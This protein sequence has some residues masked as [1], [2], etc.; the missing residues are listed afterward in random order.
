[1][2]VS[3]KQLFT[4]F[5][6]N[7]TLRKTSGGWWSFKCPFCNE[8]ENREKMAIQFQYGVVKCWICSYKDYADRFVSEYEGVKLSEAKDILRSCKPATVK[9]DDFVGDSSL[10]VSTVALPVGYHSITEMEGN[11]MADRARTYLTKRGFDIQEL[12]R[13]GVGFCYHEEDDLK[14]DDDYFGYVIIPFKSK[15][16]LVYF[17]G[18]DYFGNFLRY[19]NPAKDLTGVGKGDVLFNEDALNIYDEVFILEGWADAL[20]MGRAAISTQG[21]SLSKKQKLK[22]LNGSCS[23]LCFIPDAGADN[24]RET[25]YK[26]ALKTAMQFIDHKEVRVLDLNG[27]A[28]GKDVNELG[29]NRVMQ[30]YKNTPILTMA[31]AIKN[32]I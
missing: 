8:L 14:A 11:I 26:K 15:G 28:D 5:D 24:T 12:D 3:P 17:I 23:S 27:I 21:W 2:I 9:L 30:V 6:T 31:E 10:K 18:R 19:K 16:Q 22:I 1:M 25:F 13:L 7:F 20:T 32:L 29:K 4:Y